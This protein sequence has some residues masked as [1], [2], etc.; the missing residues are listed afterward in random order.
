MARALGYPRPVTP[1][2]PQRPVHG[3]PLVGATPPVPAARHETVLTAEPDGS[4]E[5]LRA[6]LAVDDDAA[7]RSALERVAAGH[8]TLLE[9]WARLSEWSL[10]HGD[11]VA[12]YAFARVAYHRGLD[13]LRREGWGGT[14]L[15][16]WSRLTNRGF[17][18]GV[19]ALLAAAAAIGEEDEAARCR[20]FLL[21]LDPDDTLGVAAY[22]EA[23]GPGWAPPALPGHE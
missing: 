7:R 13:R 12:A 10:D 17:L 1:D 20:S 8:P 16:R 14:G 21:E 19:H 9:A 11:A 5:A 3:L 15:V 22:P 6:A 18:R 2:L 4:V 23:P